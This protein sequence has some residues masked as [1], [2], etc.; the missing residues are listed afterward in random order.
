MAY[1]HYEKDSDNIVTITMDDPVNRVNV[2]NDE[3]VEALTAMADYVVN[4]KERIAG[5]ILTSGKSTFFAGGDL[6]EILAATKETAERYYNKITR[7]KAAF[8][9][10]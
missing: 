2:M 6:E 9:Q 8:R 3:F 4:E 7:I 10:L 1:A 5:V